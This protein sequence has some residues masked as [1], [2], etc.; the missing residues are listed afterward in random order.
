[1]LCCNVNSFVSCL[2]TEQASLVQTVVSKDF[3]KCTIFW[4]IVV[5]FFLA[6]NGVADRPNL[7]VLLTRALPTMIVDTR[8]VWMILHV[9]YSDVFS[10][11]I[12]QMN[13]M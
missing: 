10:C 8:L 2:P 11:L 9:Y 3:E 12:L 4:N 7:I 6:C 5:F 1:M 13:T